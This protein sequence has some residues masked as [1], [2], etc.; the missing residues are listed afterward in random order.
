M[1]QV[2]EPAG[3]GLRSRARRW[4]PKLVGVGQ[5]PVLGVVSCGG[6]VGALARH[7]VQLAWPLRPGGFP[8]S[9]FTINVTG[10]LLIGVV[11]ALV[12]E[13]WMGRR[14]LRPFLGVGVLGGYTSFSAYALDIEQTL[15]AEAPRVA[16]VY[17]AATVV[18]ALVAVW[19]ASTAT[20]WLLRRPWR[21][22]RSR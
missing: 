6:V 19:A 10:C 15:V 20:H 21:K 18:T 7:G 5:W 17:L 13:V 2:T 22:R 8:W 12:A 11:M 3:S 4:R 1:A 9:T 14:L 16:L